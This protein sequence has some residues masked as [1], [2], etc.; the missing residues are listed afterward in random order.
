MEQ[1]EEYKKTLASLS[2]QIDRGEQLV[3]G[4]GGEKVRWSASQLHLEDMYEKLVGDCLMA[5]AFTSFLGPYP[6]DYRMDINSEIF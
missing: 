3:S 1:M 6:N 4:L 2:L 5:A